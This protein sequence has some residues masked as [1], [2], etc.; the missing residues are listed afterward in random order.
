MEEVKFSCRVSFAEL[1]KETVNDLLNPTSAAT[2]RVCEDASH[3]VFIDGLQD[4]EVTSGDHTPGVW[5]PSRAFGLK[6]T[7]MAYQPR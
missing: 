6:S 7:R 1:Y 2:L 3:R 4:M 5:P